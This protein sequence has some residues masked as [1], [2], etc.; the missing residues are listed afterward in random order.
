[1]ANGPAA[2]VLERLYLARM[3]LESGARD[4]SSPLPLDRMRAV[5]VVDDAAEWSAIALLG[6]LSI[7]LPQGEGAL[8]RYVEAL[9]TAKPEL[10]R[11]R[12]PI[13]RMRQLRN[14]VKHDGLIP[15]AEAAREA[16]GVV[17]D[18]LRDA[19]KAALGK[20]LEQITPVELVTED[21][22]KA[23]LVAAAEALA[24]QDFKEAVIGA[25]QAFEV[26]QSR[27]FGRLSPFSSAGRA[28]DRFVRDLFGTVA[29]AAATSVPTLSLHNTGRQ[30]VQTF[31]T[32]FARKLTT[33]GRSASSRIVEQLMKPT[34]LA[35][36]GVDL[37]DQW[38]FE[39]IT[40]DVLVLDDGR[41]QVSSPRTLDSTVDDAVFAI[42][43]ATRVLLLL[44]DWQRRNPRHLR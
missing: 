35:R 18:F 1:M 5:M 25:A 31:V 24:R 9:A 32:A 12:A 23:Y 13:G 34:R 41:T 37:A 20:S 19:V 39:D 7:S 3:A 33:E 38:H 42:D 27:F 28:D 11:H 17:E 4:V 29:D 10:A 36:F 44:E 22:P 16:A 26:G 15:S 14:R 40:P 8:G 30:E 2:R 6:E 21:E 43:F